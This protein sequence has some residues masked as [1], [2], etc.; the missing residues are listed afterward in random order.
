MSK[1]YVDVLVK[2]SKE[3]QLL[4]QSITWEDG[5]KCEVDNIKDVRHVSSLKAGGSGMRYTCQI[6]DQEKYLYYEG[7]NMWFV[8]GLSEVGERDI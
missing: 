1:L 5:R 7:N 4:P 3:G 6:G 8:E 2:F